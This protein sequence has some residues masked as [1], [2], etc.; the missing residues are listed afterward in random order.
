MAIALLLGI[1]VGYGAC[2]AGKKSKIKNHSWLV[3]EIYGGLLE[4]D[5]PGG[6]MSELAGGDTETLQRI[7]S[8]LRKAQVDDRIDGVIIRTSY[9]T[10]IGA[11][12]TEEIRNAIKRLRDSGKKVYGYAEA[13]G[14]KEL[15]LLSACDEVLS[16][17][18]AF[19]NFHGFAFGSVHVK[20]ALDK[21]GIKPNMHKIKDYKSAAELVMREDMSDP[22]RENTEWMADDFWDMF[23]TTL[24]EE[25]GLSKEKISELMEHAM[26][27]A[28][29]AVEGGLVDRLMYWD[30]IETMLKRENDD[31]LRTV[32]QARY[33]QVL[34]G[35][36]GLKGKKKIAVI[37][38]QGTITGR[39]NGV[40]PL[41]GVTMGHE[42]IVAELRKA[43]ENDRVAA[44]VL[45]VDSGGGVALDSDLMGHEVEL[46]ASVKPVVVSM[47]D[48]AASGG[49]SNSYRA[50]KN[51]RRPDDRDR[52]DRLDH[53]QVQHARVL[54]QAGDNARP[55]DAG[56]DG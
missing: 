28:D 40:N 56:A 10:S 1:A 5:P 4:Y 3:V 39:K 44:V 16:P 35:K 49:Y 2:A 6:L 30:E 55:G 45:R 20:K 48:V 46:T 7:L 23:V 34:P 42:S 14:A 43:R 51:R 26:F 15:L 50:T 29:E 38:A 37:H 24:S 13:F 53:R 36:L 52:L 18:S 9:G 32:S 27:T 19:I 33:A 22:A 8:N 11:A 47:V 41:L 12:K 21:L 17:P 25:R 54:R 31:K